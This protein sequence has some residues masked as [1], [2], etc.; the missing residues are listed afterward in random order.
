VAGAV[1]AAMASVAQ[2]LDAQTTSFGQ[3]RKSG[4]ERFQSVPMAAIFR[5]QPP[6]HFA[7]KA[8]R[9]NRVS[10][11]NGLKITQV[12]ATTSCRKSSSA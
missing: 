6:I 3:A 2:K 4:V 9:V 11:G 1:E 7:P 5:E 10:L 8:L 12:N